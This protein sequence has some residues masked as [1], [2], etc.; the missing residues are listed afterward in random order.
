MRKIGDLW[1]FDTR[2]LMRASTC[3]HCTTVSVAHA[4]EIPDVESTLAQYIKEQE[5]DRLSGK[6]LTLPMKYGIKYEN[7]LVEE[8]QVTSGSE[9][10]SGPEN[11]G[12]ISETIRLL[13]AGTPVIYQGGLKHEDGI[14]LFSGRPDLL[15]RDDWHLVFTPEGL[16][17]EK[18]PGADFTGYTAWDVKFASKAKAE[19]ALQVAIY[20]EGLKALGMKARNAK[21][22]VVLGNRTLVLLNENEIVPAA[23]LARA[24]LT[25]SIERVDA[26]S[27]AQ[28]IRSGKF[29]W[30]CASEKECTICEYPKLCKQSREEAN[31][32]LLIAG[33]GKTLRSKLKAAGLKSLEDL[34]SHTGKKPKGV[35][36][37][38]YEKAKAQAEIQLRQQRANSE[39]IH[40]LL[41]DPELRYLPQ[42]DPADVFFDMEG[43]PYFE[44]GG[45]EYLFGNWTRENKFIPFWAHDRAEEKDAFVRFMTWVHQRMMQ[46]PDAHIYHYASYEQTALRRLSTRHGVMQTELSELQRRGRFVDLY[47]I[48]L[49]SVRVGEPKYSIK[50]L[51]NHYKF[52][53]EKIGDESVATAADSIDGYEDW[54]LLTIKSGDLTQ[55]IE[56]RENAAKDAELLLDALMR[57]NRDDVKSTL[58]LHSWLMGM[59]GAATLKPVAKPELTN[60]EEA[61][62]LKAQ[63]ELDFLRDT[64]EN[65][66]AP[67]QGWEKGKDP[68][69]DARYSAWEALA[70]SILFYRRERVMQLVDLYIRLGLEEE[71]L[72]GDKASIPVLNPKIIDEVQKRA[73]GPITVVYEADLPEESIYRPQPGDTLKVGFSRGGAIRDFHAGDV[74]EVFENSYT[75]ARRSKFGEELQLDPVCIISHKDFS[76]ENKEKS[77]VQLVAEITS[78][79]ESPANEPPEGFAALDLVLREEPRLTEGHLKEVEEDDYLPSLI[80]SALRMDC[81][82]LAV[83]GPPGTGKTYLASHL[84]KELLRQGKRIAVTANSHSAIENLLEGCIDAEVDGGLIFKAPKDKSNPSELWQFEPKYMPHEGPTVYGA[85]SFGMC[86]Q[87]AMSHHFDYLIVDEAAQF[88]LVD[89]LASSAIASNIILFGDPQQLPQVVLA[90]HPGGVEESALGHFMNDSEIIPKGKGYFVAVTRRLHPQVNKVVSKLAYNNQLRS[91]ELTEKFVLSDT[92]PGVHAIKVDHQN[93]ST[94]SPEEVDVVLGLVRKHRATL[95][96]EEILVV[97]PYNAQ[98]NAIKRALQDN[99]HYDVKVG[100]VDRFQGRQGLVVIY[101]FAAS[102]AEDAPRG[103]GFLLDRNR[104]NVAISRAKSVCYL[105]YSQDLL[106]AS[107]SSIEDVKSVSRL[108]GLL[109]PDQVQTS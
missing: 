13:E 26:I 106:K 1:S 3:K 12:D 87:L 73:N 10:V 108:A 74:L 63:E 52:K 95:P 102:S 56:V 50:N 104:M 89:S 20:I 65:L 61:K 32:L 93:N 80:D 98:V 51:E 38:S 28:A 79:W 17:A 86:N 18:R 58:W 53:R 33:V 48:V 35:S 57:Y 5:E 22:G 88:S 27:V 14:T 24:Q 25:E 36:T 85:T 41:P 43:F 81:T 62:V 40:E 101:S 82:T 75:F 6:S 70:N 16:K 47:P 96:A 100:T 109:S 49:R 8:L 21:H 7:Q 15:V 67:L 46:N 105:I 31:D 77:V 64:T 69:L 60:E 103:L 97:A 2:D 11:E 54:R 30:H 42:S 71:E 66:F 19:Y 39:P 92:P 68:E 72:L 37:K 78:R 45:L 107:F 34:V 23:R 44:N 9:N 59:A 83:Q 99:G 94:Y 4:M 76:T 91:H 90:T 29:D 84:I 55:P